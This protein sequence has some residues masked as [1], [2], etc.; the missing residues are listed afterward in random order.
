M[1][2]P[3]ASL[4]AASRGPGGLAAAAPVRPRHYEPGEFSLELAKLGI[5]RSTGWVRSECHAGR[6]VTLSRFKRR[7]L[8]PESELFRI[9]GIQEEAS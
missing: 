8:I 1:P 2:T 7:H 4:P 3:T 6:I 9:A 5:R